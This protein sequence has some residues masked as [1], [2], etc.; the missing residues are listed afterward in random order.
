M[1][2]GI[3]AICLVKQGVIIIGDADDGP[4]DVHFKTLNDQTRFRGNTGKG[5]GVVAGGGPGLYTGTGGGTGDMSAVPVL[6]AP[7]AAGGEDVGS[8]NAP[9]EVGAEGGD[10]ASIQARVGNG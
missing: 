5:V 2:T 9:A 4:V 7:V 10:V 8:H 6:I 1:Q 3:A